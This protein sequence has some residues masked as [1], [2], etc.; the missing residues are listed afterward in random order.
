M[1][2]HQLEE[3]LASEGKTEDEIEYFIRNSMFLEFR[4]RITIRSTQV[5]YADDK[6]YN[7]LEVIESLCADIRARELAK[8]RK[9]NHRQGLIDQWIPI[10]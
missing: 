7:T 4:K 2:I 10:R 3:V 5:G 8:V 1:P 9:A 6:V